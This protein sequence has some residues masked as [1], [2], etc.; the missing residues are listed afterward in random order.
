M[1][2]TIYYQKQKIIQKEVHEKYQSISGEKNSKTWKKARERH[3]NLTEKEKGKK[4]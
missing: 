4:A 2:N 3:Q 1:I